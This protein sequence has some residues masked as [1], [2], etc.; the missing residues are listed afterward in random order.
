MSEM[1]M[2]YRVDRQQ[3]IG[4]DGR[5]YGWV[6]AYPPGEMGEEDCCGGWFF[7]LPAR[8]AWND[9]DR[10]TDDELDAVIASMQADEEC[11]PTGEADIEEAAHVVRQVLG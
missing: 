4:D 1:N 8:I 10:L 11:R 3:G 7:A 9:R 2:R 6:G 5:V